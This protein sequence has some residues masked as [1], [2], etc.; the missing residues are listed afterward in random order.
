M[1]KVPEMDYSIE[2][3]TYIIMLLNLYIIDKVCV[4]AVIGYN[5]VR[6]AEGCHLSMYQPE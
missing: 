6:L 2:E 5:I 1:F 4:S 3:V